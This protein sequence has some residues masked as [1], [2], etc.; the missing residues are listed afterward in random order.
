MCSGCVIPGA[1]RLPPGFQCHGNQNVAAAPSGSVCSHLEPG[2]H[3]PWARAPLP[4]PVTCNLSINART[5]D[6]CH[7]AR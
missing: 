5:S 7:E 2:G 6:Q 1:P 3:P 4:H